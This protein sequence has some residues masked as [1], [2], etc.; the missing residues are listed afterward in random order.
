MPLLLRGFTGECSHPSPA[1]AR[2]RHGFVHSTDPRAAEEEAPQPEGIDLIAINQSSFVPRLITFRDF[3]YSPVSILLWCLTSLTPFVEVHDP[4]STSM[5]LLKI[6][7]GD[8][9]L[10]LTASSTPRV[11]AKSI[12]RGITHTQPSHAERL[13]QCQ[14]H[15]PDFR[16]ISAPIHL[17]IALHLLR[18][19]SLIFSADIATTISSSLP[20]ASLIHLSLERPP[21]HSSPFS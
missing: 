12:S 1:S 8:L 10:K 13:L 5:I 6:S 15:E 19:I 3:P 9:S 4:N 2:V 21:P 14:I 16:S 18:V 11:C 7:F 17:P 20:S